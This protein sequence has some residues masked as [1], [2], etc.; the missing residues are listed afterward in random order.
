MTTY[1]IKQ[2][3]TLSGIAKRH[4]VTVSAIQKANS[5]L[6][7]NVNKIS[8]GWV[9]NIPSKGSETHYEEIGKA[10]EKALKDV[11]NLKSVQKLNALLGG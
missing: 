4:G 6:I 9:L 5:N 3:D 2:G 10:F 1:K 11:Q 8:V 7:Q